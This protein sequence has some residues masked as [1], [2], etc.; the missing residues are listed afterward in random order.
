MEKT[1][2][3]KVNN[4][5]DIIL[6]SADSENKAEL[7]RAKK[8]AEMWLLN[9]KEKLRRETD[10]I[11]ADANKRAEDIRRRQI[12]AAERERT[13]E[14]LRLRNKILSEAMS[15]FNEKV[16][17]LRERSD[18]TDILVGMCIDGAVALGKKQPLKVR[19]A[20]SDAH[21]A[22]DVIRAT[23]EFCKGYKLSFDAEPAPIL[24]GCRIITEDGRKQA[25]MDWQTIT[26]EKTGELAERLLS[27]L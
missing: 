16:S 14:T 8:E 13:T 25:N 6:R 9:E 4:L 3:E 5:R 18:Y 1:S 12:L 23:A 15:M 11:I 10:I 22:K 19:F 17:R 20:A 27:M 26:E 24:G 2:K 21:L 7:E